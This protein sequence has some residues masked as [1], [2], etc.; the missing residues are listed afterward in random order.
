M[1]WYS[2]NGA[3]WKCD[4]IITRES[5]RGS[6]LIWV[7]SVLS[8]PEA[9]VDISIIRGGP[10]DELLTPRLESDHERPPLARSA[11]DMMLNVL[12]ID[13]IWGTDK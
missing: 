3:H 8:E 5:E 9:H 1:T 12:E 10:A 6:L 11:M 2:E 7:T 4:V 13:D